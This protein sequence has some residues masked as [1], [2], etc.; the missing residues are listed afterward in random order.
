MLLI[1]TTL[2]VALVIMLVVGTTLYI[3]NEN[4][5][6]KALEQKRD[7]AQNEADGIKYQMGQIDNPVLRMAM[8]TNY[9]RAIRQVENYEHQIEQLIVDEADRKLKEIEKH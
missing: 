7:T 1:L 4:T 5:P 9:R 6:L 2:V 3:L 8:E